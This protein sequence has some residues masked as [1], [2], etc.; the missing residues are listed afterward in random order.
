MTKAEWRSLDRLNLLP[1]AHASPG[2]AS[3]PLRPPRW[4]RFFGTWRPPI[5]F[6][7][8]AVARQGTNQQHR[9]SLDHPTEWQLVRRDH[10]RSNRTC[11]VQILWAPSKCAQASC[12]RGILG[13]GVA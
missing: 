11:E 12:T 7:L 3:R 1:I 6:I 10:I 2:R 13:S 8:A 4:G 9:I 5:I